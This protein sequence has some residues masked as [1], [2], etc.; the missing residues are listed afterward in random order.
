[1]WVEPEDTRM[2]KSI[3]LQQFRER[4]P[5]LAEV[6]GPVGQVEVTTKTT[7]RGG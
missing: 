4:Y 6:E 7:R 5:E 3:I 2:E 1:V